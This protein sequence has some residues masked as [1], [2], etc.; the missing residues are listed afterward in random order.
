MYSRELLPPPEHLIHNGTPVFGTFEGHP[1]KLD[2]RGV[3][4]PF[5]NINLPHV[6]TDIRI[7]SILSFSFEAGDYI[8][9]IDFFDEKA[10]GF[11]ELVLWNKETGRKFS[12]NTF[13]G[14]RRRFIPHSLEKGF[15]SSFKK[16]RYIRIS[17]NHALN[18]ISLVFNMKGDSLRPDARGAFSGR[19]MNENTCE[20]TS[21]IPHPVKRRCSATY[22]AVSD[23][24]GSIFLGK[25]KFS[26][27]VSPGELSGT[28]IL[29]IN[30]SYYKFYNSRESLAAC[31]EV[32]GKKI[33]FI[34]S[35]QA[36]DAVETDT[37]NENI[38]IVNGKC[39]PL[40]S[41][42]ITHPM[43][44]TEKWVIQDTENMVDLT[45]TPKSDNFRELSL[46]VMSSRIHTVYGV[47]EGSLRI[48]DD[49]CIGLDGFEGIAANQLMRL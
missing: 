6:F 14:P 22:T 49:E 3:R 41:V 10:F 17:W 21:V 4:T 26:D 31:G 24:K 38:L 11:A 32:N 1:E 23:I 29:R 15:C 27:E 34:L 7:R 37:Y 25:T 18:R 42:T 16:K 28:S 2:I 9:N 48:S 5:G 19:F 13:M 43:G 33:G 30:R 35:Q 44:I 47:F 12:Y 45:F 20:I 40:P 8:G 36:E 46:F 39:I